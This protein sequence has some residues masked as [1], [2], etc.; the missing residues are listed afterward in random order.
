MAA[1]ANFGLSPSCI[2]IASSGDNPCTLAG[3]GLAQPG[4]LALSLGTSDTLLGV[5]AASEAKPR[6]EGHI[7]AHPTDPD[8]VFAMLCYKNGGVARQAVRDERCGGHWSAFD[9]VRR[10]S[11]VTP[12]TSVTSVTSVTTVTTVTS[13]TSVISLSRR[14]AP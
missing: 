14:G 7:M 12:V 6:V 8:A 4:D 10:R 9:E 5:T 1:G 3:L 13:V 11:T 2:V